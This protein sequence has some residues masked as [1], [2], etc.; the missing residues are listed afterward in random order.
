MKKRLAVFALPLIALCSCGLAENGSLQQGVVN[1]KVTQKN[2]KKLYDSSLE[3]TEELE[4]LSDVEV[5]EE[6]L[7]DETTPSTGP[8]EEEQ[9]VE[10]SSSSPVVDDTS[11]TVED[12]T[13][14]P[15]EEPVESKINSYHVDYVIDYAFSASLGEHKVYDVSEQQSYSLTYVENEDEVF[16]KMNLVHSYKENDFA[17]SQS[18]EVIYQQ[19][20]EGKYRLFVS[21]EITNNW[22]EQT[23]VMKTSHR[24]HPGHIYREYGDYFIS[25]AENAMLDPTSKIANDELIESLLTS[26]NVEIVD[27]DETTV[28][29]KFL[30]EN[31]DTTMVFDTTLNAFTSITFDKSNELK[32]IVDENEAN[33][34]PFTIDNYKYMVSMNFTYNNSTM[35]KL[36]EEEMMEYQSRGKDYSHY[37]DY[38]G[39]DDKE[40][41][42]HSY[43]GG[44]DPRH[45]YD[46]GFGHRPDDRPGHEEDFHHQEPENNNDYP[47][48]QKDFAF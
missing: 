9:P 28:K 13:S 29:V 8:V 18:I 42:D 6:D 14:T 30:Y 41:F 45:D 27:V 2:V 47:Q 43:H 20:E 35:D 44:H 23:Y 22:F 11:S 7:M 16:L 40:D 34:N 4:D 39:R 3:T 36:S 31:M 38:H 33:N 26:E 1:D 10:D 19:V 25:M 46:D 32:E 48:D 24:I 17:G 15:V 37:N 12:S 21:Q 5:T